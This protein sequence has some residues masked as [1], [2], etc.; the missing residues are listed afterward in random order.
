MPHCHSFKY[1]CFSYCI[2]SSYHLTFRIHS[3]FYFLF[4]RLNMWLFHLF[5]RNEWWISSKIPFYFLLPHSRYYKL[6]SYYDRDAHNPYNRL[7]RLLYFTYI[8]SNNYCDYN[9]SMFNICTYNYCCRS[10]KLYD[11]FRKLNWNY[12]SIYKCPSWMWDLYI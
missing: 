10:F 11:I 4:I 3:S 2:Y 5:S 8:N 12:S 6:R 1:S 7:L 9:R